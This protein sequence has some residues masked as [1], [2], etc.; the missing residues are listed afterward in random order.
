MTDE[1][2]SMIL[3][4]YMYM[5]YKEADDG[6]TVNEILA[7]MAS[8]PDYQQGGVHYGEYTVLSKAAVNPEIGEL[9]IGDQS[10]LMNY[11]TGT[12]ACTF[13][14][15]DGS[16]IYVVYRGTGD[17]EWPDNGIGMTQSSTIQQERALDY[18]ETVVER[19]QISV[20]QKLVVTGHSK[21]G[22]KAKYVTM[23]TR[24]DNLLDACYDIDGQG[25]SEKTING[26]KDEY[27]EEYETRRA[28]ITGIYGENDYVNVLGTSI[29]P[30]NQIHYVKT[31]VKVENFAGY[32]DIKYMFAT[33]EKDPVTGKEVTVFHG[34]KNSYVS[35]QGELGS[36]AALLSL[37]M[38]K[39]EPDKRDG[40]AASLMQMMEL[41]GERKTGINGERLTIS[42]VG[43]FLG[44]G[45]PLIAGTLLGTSEGW[46]MLYHGVIKKSFSQDVNGRLTV[47]ADKMS[48]LRQVQALQNMAVRMRTYREEIDNVCSALPEFMKNS[49]MLCHKIKKEAEN[50][51][52]EIRELEK[53]SKM[54]ESI[55]KIYMTEDIRA[56]DEILMI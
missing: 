45:V 33:L 51:D 14:T 17:G 6:M 43:D 26:W 49:W 46:N 7:D 5:D 31:P 19:E 40:C 23:S 12:C 28:R 16:S 47:M 37:A 10:H 41:A 25:F 52:R 32:H 18:F 34:E 2:I 9:I 15:G 38:M 39:L 30:E 36:Y 50:L 8:L 48:L 13:Q 35:K 44:T 53:L 3:N 27:G 24:Y 22:N 54:L 11:D 42:D 1:E 4:T 21:G 29:V 56:A 55:V 20:E